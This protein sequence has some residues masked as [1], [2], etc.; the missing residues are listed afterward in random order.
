MLNLG[1]ELVQ[2]YELLLVVEN[3]LVDLD[4]VLN[5]YSVNLAIAQVFQ[6]IK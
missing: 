6:I 3:G 5:R 4:T 2:R 1:S